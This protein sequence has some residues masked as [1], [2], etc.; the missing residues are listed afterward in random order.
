M[1][2]HQKEKTGR[3]REFSD[4]AS[5]QRSLGVGMEKGGDQKNNKRNKN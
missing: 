2:A 4:E 3:E 5:V 1:C